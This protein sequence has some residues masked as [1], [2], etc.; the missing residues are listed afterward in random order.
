MWTVT[1]SPHLSGRQAALPGGT[2]SASLMHR[3]SRRSRGFYLAAIAGCVALAV[4]AVAA[5]RK[6]SAPPACQLETIATGTVKTVVDGRSFV[7]ADGREVRLAGIEVP[8]LP[9][10]SRPD[11]AAGGGE[12]AQKE[13]AAKLAGSEIVLRQAEAQPTDR[14]GR[15]AGYGFRTGPDGEILLQSE[16]LA[17][18]FARVAT[19]AGDRACAADSIKP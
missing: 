4:P 13:L 18:G 8:P 3:P 9:L 14:Y 1:L 5:T 7:L 12:A 19:R 16:L 15:L 2:M 17:A 6:S 10:P 11:P